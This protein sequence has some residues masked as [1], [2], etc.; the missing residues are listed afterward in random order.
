MQQH[1]P[2]DQ[3][4]VLKAA[5]ESERQQIIGLVDVMIDR[6]TTTKTRISTNTT[7]AKKPTPRPR[8]RRRRSAR[9]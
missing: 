8:N 7:K 6:S 2:E 1:L 4:D 5:E 9:R 3:F